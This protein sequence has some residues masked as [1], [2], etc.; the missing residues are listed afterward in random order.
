MILYADIYTFKIRCVLI[1]LVVLLCM[2][3]LEIGK[4]M[5]SSTLPWWE[6]DVAHNIVR[7]NA[8]KVTVL[9]YS[10]DDFKDCGYERFTDLLHPE[11]FDR[12]MN[13]MMDVLYK[14]VDL[15]QTDYRIR[16][17][18]GSYRWFIDRGFVMN[19][20]ESGKP[21]IIKGIVLNAGIE[22]NRQS[23]Q[24]ILSFISKPVDERSVVVLC[25]NC[26]K[27]YTDNGSWEFLTEETIKLLGRKVSHSICPSCLKTLYPEFADE[28]LCKHG[29]INGGT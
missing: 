8:V 14:G 11:D 17:V 15:Y 20:N 3:Y 10:M 1:K 22:H 6:W 26:R 9:G 7:F 28:I 2:D 13:A 19:R 23:V 27:L 25:A 24:N 16:A 12:T 29:G 18:D 5:E 21:G 4:I